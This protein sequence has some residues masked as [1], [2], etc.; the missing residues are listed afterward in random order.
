MKPR[1]I[2]IG[3]IAAAGK[4]TRAY[5]RTSFIPKP[6]FTF[7]QETILEKNVQLMF[8]TLGVKKLYIVVGHLKEMVLE[9]IERIRRKYPQFDIESANWTQKG[10]A[11]DIA[12][13]EGRIHDDF[14]VILGD[15]FYYGT[16]HEILLTDWKKHPRGQSIIGILE[17]SLLSD[18]RKNY[19][20]ELEGARIKNLVEKPE[21][22]PNNLLGLGTYVFTPEFFSHFKATPPSKRSGVIELT[23]VIDKMARETG[24]VY[25]S[26]FKGRYFNI[27]SL[28]DYYTASYLIRSDK[29]PQYKISLVVP[30]F[31]NPSTLTDV[32]RDFHPHVHEIVVM[33]MGSDTPHVPRVSKV[34]SMTA[35][36]RTRGLY[37][38]QA[39]YNAMEQCRGDIIVL[40]PPDGSFRARDLPKLLEY[41]KDCDMVV[42][43]RT[44]RQLIEQGANLRPIYRWLNVALGKAV[45]ILWWGQEPRFTDI[46]CMYRAIWRDSFMKIMPDLKSPGKTYSVEMMIEVVRYHMRCVEIPVSFYKRY[47]ALPED[48]A[49]EL[50]KY[51]FSVLFLIF[52]R[53]FGIFRV[54]GRLFGQ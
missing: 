34:R 50:W 22:P 54:L 52:S 1:T 7:E 10:L 4:G 32:L 51:F 31:N 47:G 8:K 44:T 15:E 39:I 9:E 28:A 3:V 41:L 23:D 48:S 43:T 19:S 30:S 42:G 5:P 29:F 12:S 25:A 17:S 40:V 2:K 20:V 53:R 14:V 46:G 6:L 33:D 13:L 11:A 36:H 21:N 49:S 27:N 38:A 26:I 45:E 37:N 24:E 16:N 18:I 35:A